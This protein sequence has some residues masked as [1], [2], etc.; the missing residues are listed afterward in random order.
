M[1]TRLSGESLIPLAQVGSIVA[2]NPTRTTVW[3]WARHGVNGIRLESVRIGGRVRTSR[4]A[5]ER[6]LEALNAEPAA[7]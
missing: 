2:T 7:V 4:E 1:A 6:F 3:G 5:V